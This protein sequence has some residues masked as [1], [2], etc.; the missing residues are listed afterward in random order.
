M[1]VFIEAHFTA[2]NR[3]FVEAFDAES[4]GKLGI[5]AR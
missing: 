1:P 2:E 5:S 4:L 3:R